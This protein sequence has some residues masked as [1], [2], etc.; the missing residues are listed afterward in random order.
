[1]RTKIIIIVGVVLMVYLVAL[2]VTLTHKC[3][4]NTH[5]TCDGQCVCDGFECID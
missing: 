1:M 5:K 4:D 3:V 2:Q